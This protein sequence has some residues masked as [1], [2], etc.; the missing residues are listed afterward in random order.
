MVKNVKKF[1]LSR[2][3]VTR[4]QATAVIVIIVVA[5]IAG[6]AIYYVTRPPPAAEPIKIGVITPLSAPADYISGNL[7]LKTAELFV[8]YQNAKG[9]VLGRPLELVVG[10]QTL[11]AGTAISHLAR[12]VTEESIVGLIGP[13]E[14][15]VALPVAEATTNYPVIMFV[16][17][18]WAD[19]IT[20]NHYK[21]VFRIGVAN[22]LVSRGTMEFLKWGGY[23]KGAAICEESPY[24]IGMWDGMVKWRDELYPELELTQILT[25][26]GKTD[27]TAELMK[28]VE[29]S[30]PPDVIIMN[31]NLPH[32]NIM[33]K[34]LYE[35][36]ITPEIP[37]VTSYAFPLVDPKSFWETV[38]EAGV[39]L[40][41]QDYGS[42]FMEYSAEGEEFINLWKEEVGETP[43]VWICWFWD[44]LRILVK[45]IEDTESTDID[46]LSDYIEDIELE[47]TTGFIKLENDPTP[48][49]IMWHQWIGFTVYFFKT[50]FVGAT[51]EKQVYPPLD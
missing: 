46:V 35:M 25:P 1:S 16:A 38:S 29:M 13:W 45:A 43:P 42:P 18:S 36:G 11:D 37:M 40:I 26:P 47:G 27:Y 34:Q 19:D 31:N 39:G 24:G 12:M 21:Y 44:T 14:S 4:M 6:I 10:D 48:G 2:E 41:M 3:A 33:L 23:K 7:I 51:T 32:V 5:V 17:F 49:T 28:V 20:A 50:E 8:E 15:G 30:P 9:G 22:L